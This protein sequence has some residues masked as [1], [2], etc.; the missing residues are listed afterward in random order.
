MKCILARTPCLK[1]LLK[2]YQHIEGELIH[3]SHTYL[4]R[5]WA[6]LPGTHQ[7]PKIPCPCQRSIQY[8]RE[9]GT[10]PYIHLPKSKLIQGNNKKQECNCGGAGWETSFRRPPILI[11]ANHFDVGW[12]A[13]VQI[14]SF[15]L[16]ILWAI[17]HHIFPRGS[18]RLEERRLP[19]RICFAQYHWAQEYRGL[20]LNLDPPSSSSLL[21]PL[22]SPLQAS[23]GCTHSICLCLCVPGMS[24]FSLLLS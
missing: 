24:L 22:S 17:S 7:Y 13:S 15:V 3:L 6:Q 20:D 18:L 21:P 11:P 23:L 8:V 19:D 5:C 9:P 14:Q 4:L 12:M 2:C 16:Q 1:H 10:L